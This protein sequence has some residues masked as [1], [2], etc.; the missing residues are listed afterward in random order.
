M[1]INGFSPNQ[2]LALPLTALVVLS[3]A[4]L[5]GL[6]LMLDVPAQALAL[7][8]LALF[9]AAADR[10]LD[11]DGGERGADLRPAHHAGYQLTRSASW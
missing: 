3:P 2:E 9:V 6:N 4:F 10:P 7:A 8:S 5:P 1:A 11:L